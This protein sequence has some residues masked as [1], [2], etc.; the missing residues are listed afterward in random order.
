MSRPILHATDFSPASRAAFAKAVQL[1][2]RER[3]PLTIAHVMA[4][5]V[6][7]LGDGYV[8]PTTWEEIDRAQRATSKK[9]L[10]ALVA[11]ARAAGVRVRGLLLE[12]QPA[13]QIL[14]AARGAGLVVIGTHGR[15]GLA[16]FILGSVASR[17][18]AGARSPVLTV[19]GK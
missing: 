14:R 1:A 9:K 3:A 10:D 2:K 19:R 7:M 5:P 8:S 17:V 12:G 6:L 18:V 15:T 13:E 16:R 11:R 4:P